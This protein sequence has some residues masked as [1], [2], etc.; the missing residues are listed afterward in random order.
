[1]KKILLAFAAVVLLGTFGYLTF[2]P[3]YDCGLPTETTKHRWSKEHDQEFQ[4][5]TTTTP[6]RDWKGCLYTIKVDKV[7]FGGTGCERAYKSEQ[8]FR[9]KGNEF[10]FVASK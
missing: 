7:Y 1:M 4:I 9:K 2:S 8:V 5:R 6:S 3:Q 10:V